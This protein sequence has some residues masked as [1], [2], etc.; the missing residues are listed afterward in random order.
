MIKAKTLQF[1]GYQSNIINTSN[2]NCMNNVSML[3]AATLERGSFLA[4]E[5]SDILVSVL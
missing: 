3:P 2:N 5:F 1:Y 4:Y